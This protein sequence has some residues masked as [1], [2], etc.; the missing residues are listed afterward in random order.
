MKH[1]ML[2]SKKSSTPRCDVRL[3]GVC[4]CVGVYSFVALRCQSSG[5]KLGVNASVTRFRHK[6]NGEGKL[7][8]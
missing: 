1:L 7:E 6:Q 5:Y 8:M 4:L 3:R 2:Q